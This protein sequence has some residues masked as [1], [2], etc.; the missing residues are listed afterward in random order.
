MATMTCRCGAVR[1][2]FPTSQELFRHECC[3]HDCVSALW[4]S[5]QHGGP[6]CHSDYLADCC[7]LPND[8]QILS[9]EKRI[10]AFLNYADA[11]TTRFYCTD[12]W[13]ILFQSH[14]FYEEQIVVSQIAAYKG[15]EGLD[16][17]Q[18]MAPQARHFLKDR[19]PAELASLPA[20]HGDPGHLY[21]SVADNLI[22]SFPAMKAAGGKGRTLNAQLLLE[23]IGPPLVPTDAPR[24]SAGPPS[25]A[26]QGALD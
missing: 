9:G 1:I 5:T 13:T 22:D 6:A 17:I 23:K 25:L 11:D 19:S 26:R 24:L 15:F 14:D 3:C 8:F 4:Y 10:G 16:D 18:R 20:W 21:Q 7:W 12:C 2:R